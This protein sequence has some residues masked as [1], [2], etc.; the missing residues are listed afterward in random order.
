MV[1]PFGNKLQKNSST[2]CIQRT[3]HSRRRRPN[4]RRKRIRTKFPTKRTTLQAAV[5]VAPVILRTKVTMPWKRQRN[6]IV[7]H[8]H[9]DC[10]STVH[11]AIWY[12]AC[13]S[14]A[15]RY[16]CVSY[17]VRR[18]LHRSYTSSQ[19]THSLLLSI[20]QCPTYTRST[21]HILCIYFCPTAL[22]VLCSHVYML[23]WSKTPCISRQ[24]C[25]CQFE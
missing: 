18:S 20:T 19:L 23:L 12:W 13:C 6:G 10:P 22:C 16:C 1:W 17:G 24:Q 25:Q 4:Q 7:S 3:T 5:A 14:A 2:K 8:L 9:E 15:V 11:G 21:P